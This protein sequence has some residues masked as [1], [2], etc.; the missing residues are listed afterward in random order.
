MSP[1]ITVSP[2][3]TTTSLTTRALCVRACAAPAARLDL[4]RHA[5]V[6]D[7]EHALR[8]LEQ[9]AAEIGDE[10]EGV[11]VDL[12]VVDDAGE[13][14]ALLGG[15]ELDLVADEVVQRPV[16]HGEGVDVEIRL[17]LDRRC[18]DARAGW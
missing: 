16:V 15:I 2:S 14:V 7:L 17:D 10:T 3:Y 13:L 4:Q 8:A 11:D 1:T 5:L 12:H 18:G 6:G 9:P